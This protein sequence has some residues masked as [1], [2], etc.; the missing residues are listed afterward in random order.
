MN[1]TPGV[2]IR[3]PQKGM[4]GYKDGRNYY[5]LPDQLYGAVVKFYSDQNR[6]YPLSK[7]AL[8]KIMRE[9][10][11]IEQWDRK[12]GRT[13]KQKI[14]MGKNARYLW[15]PMW[16]V[17]DTER[18]KDPGKQVEMQEIDLDEVPFAKGD[19]DAK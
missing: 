6:V 11:I 9:D 3:A 17:D 8:F 7:S 19:D 13:T 4:C 1:I 10:G 5:F 16:R 18:P 14:I 15:L 12:A 2:E